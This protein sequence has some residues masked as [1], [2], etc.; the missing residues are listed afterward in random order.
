MMAGEKAALEFDRRT[1]CV[2]ELLE[3]DWCPSELETNTPYFRTQDDC[4][5]DR[6]SGINIFVS[7]DGDVSVHT[8]KGPCRYRTPITGG[9]LSRRT[10]NA[11]LILAL[12]I[13]WD[14]EE[15]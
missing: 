13:K 14:N 12:A 2:R 4:D 15:R 9:G 10:R 1:E 3:A 8:A 5:G 7:C 6:A 11:L